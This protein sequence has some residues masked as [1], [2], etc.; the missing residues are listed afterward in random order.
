MGEG[1][2]GGDELVDF[3]DEV[4]EGGWGEEDFLVVGDF[5]EVAVLD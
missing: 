3:E 1:F 4:G 2:V 5:T